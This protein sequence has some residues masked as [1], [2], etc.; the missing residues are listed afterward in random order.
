[1]VRSILIP[2]LFAPYL[3]WAQQAVPPAAE[4]PLTPAVLTTTDKPADTASTL[5][6]TE[7]LADTLAV[8]GRYLAA[9]HVYEQLQPTAVILNKMGIA[10]EHMF[11]WD[12]ARASFEDSIKLNPKYAEA[13]NNL[14]TL[15]HS[16]GDLAR[17]EKMYRKSLKLKPNDPNTMQNL[18][19]LYYA[20]RNFR[21]GDAEYR[22]ALAIDPGILERSANR[23]I[24]ANSKVQSASEIH[25]HLAA[26]Y[27]Q[28]GSQKM[29]LDYLRKAILEGFRDRNRLMHDKEFADMRTSDAFLAMVEDMQKN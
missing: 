24:P 17:A 26:T 25:Y 11:M 13:Y 4:T 22:K 1:M 19:T 29:A 7:G 8:R 12:R 3:L 6:P 15:S 23:G 20:K 10:C 28:A 27:A 2:L 5:P 9:I 14:G 18:G 21:K 16:Q